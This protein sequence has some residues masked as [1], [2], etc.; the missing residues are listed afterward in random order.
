MVG[1]PM[2]RRPAPGYGF[3]SLERSVECAAAGPVAAATRRRGYVHRALVSVRYALT[4]T[5][6]VAAR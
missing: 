6:V 5:G 4:F 1:S 2:R 3:A